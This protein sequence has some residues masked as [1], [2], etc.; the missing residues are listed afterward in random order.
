MIF[1]DF[2]CV[3]FL[4][5][6]CNFFLAFCRKYGKIKA[7]SAAQSCAQSRSSSP[8]LS[9]VQHTA[10]Y[11]IRRCRQGQFGHKFPSLILDIPQTKYLTQRGNV[12]EYLL[13]PDAFL[14]IITGEESM[15]K[16]A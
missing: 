13:I 10:S 4:Y 1:L 2:Y 5:M 3:I 11:G 9:S 15:T 6:Y 16:K 12:C 14:I 7:V 8:W